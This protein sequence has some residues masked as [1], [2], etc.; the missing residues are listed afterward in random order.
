MTTWNMTTWNMTIRSST[1]NKNKISV[2][3]KSKSHQSP[4]TYI[5]V[6]ADDDD[7]NSVV[8]EHD[9]SSNNVS[10]ESL[11]SGSAVSDFACRSPEP[12]CQCQSFAS[13]S[14]ADDNNNL[15]PTDTDALSRPGVITP[16]DEKELPSSF[17]DNSEV[18]SVHVFLS[19]HGRL[20]LPRMRL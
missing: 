5:P 4:Y 17:S 6:P 15:L 18:A 20:A 3:F 8:H 13:A 1:S 19:P 7:N 12:L 10:F 14:S 11:P 9:H 16:I 2:T